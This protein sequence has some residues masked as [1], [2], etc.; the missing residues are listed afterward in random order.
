MT[1][2]D[3]RGPAARARG[4]L[5]FPSPLYAIVDVD[6]T[7]PRTCRELA[8]AILAGGCRVLQLR[9]KNRPTR[10][11]LD[12]ARALGALAATTDALFIVND[13]LDVALAIGADGVHLGADDMPIAAARRLAAT[14]LIIGYSTHTLAE[15]HVARAAGADYL[16]FGPIF[17]TATKPPAHAPWGIDGLRDVCA[18]VPLP[19]VAIGGMTEAT[20]AAACGV[21]AAAVAMIS[22]LARA[23]DVATTVARLLVGLGRPAAQSISPASP[24]PS[25]SAV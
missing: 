22:E 21:G 24:K 19:I 15:A 12:V 13:R 9:M 11:V 7:R 14:D 17:P 2:L 10:D 1:T 25:S 16:C 3:T 4:R 6:A 5:R 8:A 20:A 18:A 23:E